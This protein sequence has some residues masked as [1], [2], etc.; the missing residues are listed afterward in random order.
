[1]HSLIHNQRSRTKFLPM[2]QYVWFSTDHLSKDH[3]TFENVQDVCFSFDEEFCSL[4]RVVTLFSFLVVVVIVHFVSIPF[5]SAIANIKT[6]AFVYITA[7]S[8][9]H[10]YVECCHTIIL[11]SRK[12]LHYIQV[13]AMSVIRQYF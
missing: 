2:I 12:E 7:K 9:V 6:N 10:T 5:S 4:P 3:D 13:L 11:I 1:M 8:I